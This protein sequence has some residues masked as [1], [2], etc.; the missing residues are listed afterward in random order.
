M[1][2]PHDAYHV[3]RGLAFIE[4]QCKP[5][6][7]APDSRLSFERWQTRVEH[8]LDCADELVGVG[9]DSQ[10]CFHGELL[11]ELVPLRVPPTHKDDHLVSELERVR[12]E[13]DTLHK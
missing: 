3:F 11:E 1:R 7:E 13:F 10:E 5:F 9:T 2:I 6:P 12:L 8:Q 4:G